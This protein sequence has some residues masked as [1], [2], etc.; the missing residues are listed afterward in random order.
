[1]VTAL[2]PEKYL[3]IPNPVPATVLT[4]FPVPVQKKSRNTR[5][6]QQTGCSFPEISRKI[7]TAVYKNP[8][9]REKIFY[10]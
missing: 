6:Q 3:C 10:K 7:R 9:N 1:M 4:S 2:L 8:E 5:M